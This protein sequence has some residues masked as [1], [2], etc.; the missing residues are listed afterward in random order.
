MCVCFQIYS[1]LIDNQTIINLCYHKDAI[2][3]PLFCLETEAD[4]Y[5]YTFF[6]NAE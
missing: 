4:S 5:L 2:S 6:V 1:R 3:P